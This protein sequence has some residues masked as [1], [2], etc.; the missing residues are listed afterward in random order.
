[1]VPAGA[2]TGC[3]KTYDYTP[4]DPNAKEYKYY[5]PEV[6][7]VALEVNIED[8]ERMELI[9][10]TKNVPPPTTPTPAQSAPQ[11]PPAQTPSAPEPPPSEISEAQARSIALARVSGVVT[12]IAI[13]TKFGKKTYVVE[14]K[15]AY[16][17]EK[18]VIIDIQTGA[19]LA[20]E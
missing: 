4:L 1:V 20:V 16:G 19:I 7:G 18:D 14:I 10:V 6:Q 13:E 3:L 8:N 9:S 17:A 5:C 12:D 2:F 15:P 11:T